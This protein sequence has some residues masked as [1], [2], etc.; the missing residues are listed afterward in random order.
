MDTSVAVLLLLLVLIVLVVVERED[1]R[2]R[3]IAALTL[4]RRT[5]FVEDTLRLDIW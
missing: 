5:A 2:R 3:D 4:T 1:T